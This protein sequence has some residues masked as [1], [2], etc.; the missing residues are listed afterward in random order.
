MISHLLGG[1]CLELIAVAVDELARVVASVM[2]GI[3]I[4][5][6]GA[7]YYLLFYN[8]PIDLL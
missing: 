1:L 2:G 5:L 8:L 7:G 6:S 3:D 4:S